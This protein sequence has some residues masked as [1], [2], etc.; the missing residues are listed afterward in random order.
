MDRDSREYFLY[1][2]ADLNANLSDIKKHMSTQKHVQR[3]KSN[4]SA[5]QSTLP[6]LNKNIDSSKQAEAIMA[7]AMVLTCDHIGFS[8]F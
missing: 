1:C 7:M 6:F 5:K 3:S 2:K 8:T 4:T